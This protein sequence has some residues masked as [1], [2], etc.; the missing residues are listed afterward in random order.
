MARERLVV[1]IDVGTTKICTVIARVT[2]DDPLEVIGVGVTR[3][4]ALRKGVVVSIEQAA[5]DIQSSIAK[6][7][8]QS[9]FKILSAYVSIS[10]S[11]LQ[12]EDAHGSITIRRA[13][14][15]IGEEEVARVLDAARLVSQ[16]PDREVIDLVPRRFSVDGQQEIATPVGM[17][18]SRLEVDA[19]L[20]TGARSAIQ[21]LTHCVERAGVSI[22]ALVPQF[23]AAGE[24]V[25]TP[26]ER[27]L[28]VTLVDLGGGATD[29]AVF[30]EGGLLYGAVLPVGG[31]QVTN[32]IAVRLRTPYSAAEEI[33]L[34]HGQ[35]FSNGREEDRL[36]DVSSFDTDESSPV[37]V[38]T[39]CDTIED[40]LV[41]T[42]ERVRQRLARAGFEESL[43]AGT[44]LVGGTAQLHGIR[45]LA[46]E[47]L[48]SPVRVAS[49]GGMSGLYEQLSTPAHATSVG[50]L[51][52]GLRHGEDV[53]SPRTS[54]L[55]EAVGSL[56]NWL[57][58]FLP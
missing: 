39:L 25:L 57:K 6:A 58:G 14:R 32:D 43:P 36:I 49:P 19:T 7:E 1:G 13:D 27:D 48:E 31:Q 41:D 53:A 2:D 21:N 11:H 12:T 45:R 50:L 17:L 54:P 20:V 9:G 10:G 33:K 40:R 37:S 46:A 52:W 24:A 26:A 8:Q 18:G 56:T 15:A 35:A 30:A 44:V 29:L 4:D 5:Q 51:R 22:D 28:G 42:F 23:L 3:S 55:A 16:P 34:R 47:I 38:R